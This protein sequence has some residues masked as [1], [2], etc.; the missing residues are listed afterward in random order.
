MTDPASPDRPARFFPAAAERLRGALLDSRQRWRDL[1]ALSADL[2]FETDDVGRLTFLHPDPALGWANGMIVGKD[3]GLLLSDGQDGVGFNPFRATI[4]VRHRRVWLRRGD[5]GVACLAFAAEPLLDTL[6]RVTGARGVGID[7]TD[8][9]AESA[10]IAGALRM[11]EALDHILSSMGREVL[12]PRMLQAA[13]DAL[14]S[15][16]G[17]EGAAVIAL[18]RNGEP[19][20]V[21]H[22]AGPGAALILP[23]A[24]IVLNN[25]AETPVMR[26][27]SDGRPLLADICRTRF[28]D[29][30]GLIVWRAP[31]ARPWNNDDTRLLASSGKIV[32]MALE[33]EAIQ[34]E[35]MRQARTDPLTGLLNRRAFR[36]EV[37]RHTARTEQ[38]ELPA[39]L[40][41]VDLDHFKTVNDRFGHEAGDEVL[42]RTASLLRETF[43]PGDLIARLGGDEFALWLGGT[44]HMTAAERAE[45]LRTSVPAALDDIIGSQPPRITLSIGIATRRARADEDIDGLLRRAD[46]AMYDAKRHGRGHWRVSLLEGT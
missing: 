8:L 28:G 35:M 39:T 18:P 46:E 3:A 32:R 1:V 19:P 4:R 25:H 26:D 13:L 38:E 36:E 6:G 9:D 2:A 40:M 30:A 43:R 42:R 20:R 12:A 41:F 17:A 10:R 14:V 27:L 23:E 7:M 22:T 15:T 21:A 31:A 34:N 45:K 5:G 29:E 16:L 33:H 37:L 44:D 11:G 24:V